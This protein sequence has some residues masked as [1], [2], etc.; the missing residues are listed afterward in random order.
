MCEFKAP[1]VQLPHKA[2]R[3]DG[4]PEEGIEQWHKE[5]GL[6]GTYQPPNK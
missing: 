6:Y 3:Y 4:Y 5:K 2:R 1:H